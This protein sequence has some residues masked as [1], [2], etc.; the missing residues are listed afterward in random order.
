MVIYRL[1]HRTF[2]LI[3]PHNP[4]LRWDSYPYSI[5]TAEIRCRAGN[6]TTVRQPHGCA[7]R[8]TSIWKLWTTGWGFSVCHKRGRKT[9]GGKVLRHEKLEEGPFSWKMYFIASLF[10]TGSEGWQSPAAA[11]WQRQSDALAPRSC[12]YSHKVSPRHRNTDPSL[13]H[14][15]HICH[16]LSSYFPPLQK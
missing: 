8:Q 14:H 16:Y 13:R 9:L 5:I 15:P 6:R 7:S 4:P 11:D 3:S 1:S 2:S 10:I 12:L